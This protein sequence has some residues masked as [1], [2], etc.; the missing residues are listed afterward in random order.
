[1]PNAKNNEG[2]NIS[3]HDE[4]V[5]ARNTHTARRELIERI[6]SNSPPVAPEL[7]EV[8]NVDKEKKRFADDSELREMFERTVNGKI[9]PVSTTVAKNSAEFKNALE[10]SS[11]DEQSFIP[12]YIEKVNQ[13]PLTDLL[14]AIKNSSLPEVIKNIYQKKIE[15]VERSVLMQENRGTP[16]FT[17]KQYSSQEWAKLIDA[18]QS[19]LSGEIILFNEKEAQK[20]LELPT[21]PELPFKTVREFANRI[22]LSTAEIGNLGLTETDLDDSEITFDAEQQKKIMELYL[23]RLDINGWEI[24]LGQF[25]ATNV[26]SLL[27]RI[28]I[29]EKSTDDL[30]AFVI[31]AHEVATH[32]YRSENGARQDISIWKHGEP[33]YLETEEGLAIFME[34]IMG[35]PFGHARQR[36]FAA[37]YY[38]ISMALKTKSNEI[39]ELKAKYSPQ[40]IYQKLIDY[41][42]SETAAANTVWRIFRGTSLQHQIADI[43]ISSE[44]GDISLQVAEC[45]AKDHIYFNGFINVFTWIKKVVPYINSATANRPQTSEHS[46]K[47]SDY[48]KRLLGYSYARLVKGMRPKEISADKSNLSKYGQDFLLEIFD[49][50]ARPGKVSMETRLD[51]DMQKYI[52]S[53]TGLS[54]KKLFQPS[55]EK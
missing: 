19:L 17:A 1:M 16:K 44:Q 28:Q 14:K 12:D 8:K 49:F 25:T 33:G 52:H 5:K 27:K 35:E 22:N 18:E 30:L 24:E 26:N 6:T 55:K 2:E 43:Q 3:S 15:H 40:E 54:I 48:D 51:P 38:A 23:R 36:V 13:P 7:I 4:F 46:I 41:Q 34:Y 37:R 32:I 20:I 39:G 10:D 42:V 45:F 9:D 21:S 53:D 47:I 29:P 50:F 31:G 11:Q